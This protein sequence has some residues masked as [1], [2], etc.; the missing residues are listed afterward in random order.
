LEKAGCDGESVA[1]ASE[2]AEWDLDEIGTVKFCK[3]WVEV[4]GE[5]GGIGLDNSSSGI[6]SA[7]GIGRPLPAATN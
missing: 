3:F 5:S 4:C 7:A 2:A 6:S 1:D